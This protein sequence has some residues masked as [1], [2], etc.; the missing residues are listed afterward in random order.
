MLDILNRTKS[1]SF[2]KQKILIE[3]KN[4][5]VRYITL[6]ELLKKAKKKKPTL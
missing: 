1:N 5:N 3:D 6:Q 2:M 4:G